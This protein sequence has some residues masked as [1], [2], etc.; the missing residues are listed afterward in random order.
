MF[1]LSIIC[2]FLLCIMVYFSAPIG[3]CDGGLS[4]R[5]HKEIFCNT[6][7]GVECLQR[8]QV[9][10]FIKNVP[11]PLIKLKHIRKI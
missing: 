7:K 8:L 2:S 11:P 1:S 3:L 10:C 5:G 6:C 4:V 9:S